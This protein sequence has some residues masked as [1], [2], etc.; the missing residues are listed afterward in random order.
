[1]LK[2]L[3]MQIVTL[4]N[5]KR[6]ANFSS[7]HP[8]TFTDGTVLPAVN[9][10]KSELLKIIFHEVIENEKGDVSLSFELGVVVKDE[11]KLWTWE[12]NMD[13]VDV[14]FCPLPMLIAIAQ[15]YGDAWLW[16]SPFRG[17]RMEDRIKKLASIDKQ[18]LA[19]GQM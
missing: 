6:V 16:H 3:F 18:C 13:N 7:P 4:S 1:M 5:G 2:L 9:N 8:F 10:D 17:I 19:K 14:V 15:E 12:Y 11:M